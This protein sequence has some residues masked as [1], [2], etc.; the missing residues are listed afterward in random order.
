VSPERSAA[1]IPTW[2]WLQFAWRF[3]WTRWLQ[4][5]WIW[6]IN[7]WRS[8]DRWA[9]TDRPHHCA[10]AGPWP[11]GPAGLG[12][13]LL[14]NLA[15]LLDQHNGS[16]SNHSNNRSCEP[17][18]IITTYGDEPLAQDLNTFLAIGQ[19]NVLG[20]SPKQAR[21]DAIKVLPRSSSI[22][23]HPPRS[24]L[25][26]P[27]VE[28]VR[29]GAKLDHQSEGFHSGGF[30]SGSLI[31]ILI[32]LLQVGRGVHGRTLDLLSSTFDL[33]CIFACQIARGRLKPTFCS[34]HLC[35]GLFGHKHHR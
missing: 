23:P 12:T 9:E 28:C 26:P 15:P 14:A 11:G 6:P 25:A 13:L 19:S 8:S 18:W 3:N 1:L 34:L 33:V 2:V 10:P 4:M 30:H 21:Y 35:I 32:R 17:N 27:G 29:K 16:K 20:D 31:G 24:R 22:R 5:S 7:C